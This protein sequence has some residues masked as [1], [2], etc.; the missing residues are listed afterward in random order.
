MPTPSVVG[1]R[2]LVGAALLLTLAACGPG[3]S[4]SNEPTA[5]ELQQQACAQVRDGVDAFNTSDYED[6]VSH[7]KKAIEPATAF[8]RS[9][10]SKDADDLLDAVRYYAGLQPSEYPEAARTSSDFAK[11]KAITLGQCVPP[12]QPGDTEDPGDLAA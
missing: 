5:A 8:A 10:S 4:D 7:F 1:M 3:S 11:Y 12:G 2:S 9:T 6:T